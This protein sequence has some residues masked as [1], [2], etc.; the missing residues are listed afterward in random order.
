[1]AHGVLDSSNDRIPISLL[2][3]NREERDVIM[4]DKQGQRFGRTGADFK[5]DF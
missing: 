3:Q 4:K 1:M 2:M 5:Q